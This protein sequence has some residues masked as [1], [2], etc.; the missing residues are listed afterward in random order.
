MRECLWRPSLY[1]FDSF[2][3]LDQFIG[4]HC[5]YLRFLLFAVLILVCFNISAILLW[6]RLRW[7]F[8]GS[9]V[10]HIRL[11]S[12]MLKLWIFKFP[13]QSLWLLLVT[14]VACFSLWTLNC[15]FFTSHHHLVNI[16]I[17][18]MALSRLCLVILGNVLVPQ[19]WHLLYILIRVIDRFNT[20]YIL[21]IVLFFFIAFLVINC[22]P[23][24]FCPVLTV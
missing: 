18:S 19:A 11:V 10:V 1:H 7:Y 6:L 20:F 21:A 4:P 13:I 16:T 5:R 14:K 23:L 8:R 9:Y 15:P 12:C 3:F 22:F 17:E 24:I 2:V